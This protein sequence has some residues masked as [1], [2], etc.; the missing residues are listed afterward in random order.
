MNQ[1]LGNVITALVVDQ[2]EKKTFVQ[3]NGVTYRV[4]EEVDVEL[5]D[6]VEGFAYQDRNDNY[7]FQMEQPEIRIGTYGWAEV[8]QVKR[9][10]GV[11]V[12]T[13][14][15]NKDVVIS[16]DDLPS[17]THL[18]P[19]I[20]DRLYVTL[21]V[22]EKDRMWAKIAE[23]TKIVTISRR[24]DKSVYNEDV[25]AV[26]YASKLVGSYVIT[27]DNYLGFIHPNE[28]QYEPR[29]GEAITGRIVD[30]HSNGSVNIS[31]LKRA[32]EALEQDAAM[33]YEVL[34]RTPGQKIAF[35]DKSQ[36]DDIREFFGIS[37][38][39]FKRSLGR[40]MKSG[41]IKQENGETILIKEIEI[42]EE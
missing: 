35:T 42:E 22:D 1:D 25:E 23:D 38:A 30:V 5:G 8:V 26:V 19:K 12:D 6:A 13:G 36:P 4:V 34:K 9:G 32:H 27:S 11:F 33:I 7:R 31:M 41:L 10:L 37:K 14:L 15:D 28:R 29:L 24:A 3:K 40:L 18:W 39:S 20:G 17:E 2:N 16:M 21:T